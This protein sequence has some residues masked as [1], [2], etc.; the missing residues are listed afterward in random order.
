[1]GDEEEEDDDDDDDC[2]GGSRTCIKEA[3]RSLSEKHNCETH[4][5]I[6]LLLF[7]SSLLET[8]GGG[9]R[10]MGW[11]GIGKFRKTWHPRVLKNFKP[12]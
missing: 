5:I 10:G 11:D 12:M 4:D 3:E 6:I 9:E 1:V 2:V 8:L 7:S